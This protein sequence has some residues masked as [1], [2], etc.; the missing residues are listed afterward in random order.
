MSIKQPINKAVAPL[1]AIFINAQARTVEYIDIPKG[2]VYETVRNLVF[3]GDEKGYIDAFRIDANHYIYIDD[4][5]VLKDWD[6][7]HFFM[8]RTPPKGVCIAGNAVML[9][10]DGA[11]GGKSVSL[12]IDMVRSTVAWITPQEAHFPAPIEPGVTEWTYNSRPA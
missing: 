5:G 10:D 9:Q 8:F 4:E 6:Q 11:G 12:A 2:R 3:P 7:Q 1:R